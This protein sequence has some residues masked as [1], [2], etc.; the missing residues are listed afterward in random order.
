MFGFGSS[1]NRELQKLRAGFEQ[2]CQH[3]LLRMNEFEK[4]SFVTAF[5]NLPDEYLV[6][7]HEGTDRS[8]DDWKHLA[9]DLQEFGKEGHQMYSGLPGLHGEG[10]RAGLVAVT[11]LFLYARVNVLSEP[12]AKLLIADMNS[13]RSEAVAKVQTQIES[14]ARSR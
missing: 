1:E 12:A 13:F 9:N 5:D 2:I 4:Y 10:G 11:Y 7:V 3:V 6:E 8:K 14:R